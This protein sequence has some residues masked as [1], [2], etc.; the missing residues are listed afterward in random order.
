MSPSILG[1]TFRTRKTLDSH[2]EREKLKVPKT[3]SKKTKGRY[4]V[5]YPIINYLIYI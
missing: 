1:Y 5:V 3:Q 4:F 2:L